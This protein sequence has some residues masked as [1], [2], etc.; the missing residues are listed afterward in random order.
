MAWV[1]DYRPTTLNKVLGNEYLVE[2]LH[3]MLVLDKLPQALMFVGERGTGKTSTARI[4]ASTLMC[5]NRNEDG[6]R[7][8]NCPTCQTLTSNLIIKGKPV[9][10]IPVYQYDIAK[11]N[12]REDISKIVERIQ[13]R[14]LHNQKTV[15]ILDEIQR[16]TPEAQSCFLK[17]IEEP[18]ANVY[19]FLC[20]T[21]PEKL[22][23]PLRSRFHQMRVRKP[24]ATTMTNHLRDICER[25]GVNY[26][27]AALQIV[28]EK[29][30]CIPREAI[31]MLEF[32]SLT[33]DVTKETVYKELSLVQDQHY[34]TFF[35]ACLKGNL[36]YIM[37]M[38]ESLKQEARIDLTTFVRGLGVYVT[39][40]LK[41]RAGVQDMNYTSA[42][43]K[44]MRQFIRRFSDKQIAQMLIL[45]EN[46]CSHEDVTDFLL[47]SLAVQVAD[48]VVH[49]PT[50]HV[51][52]EDEVGQTYMA[53]TEQI[54]EQ[55]TQ[56][57]FSSFA[58][59]TPDDLLDIF[60]TTP[61]VRT[62]E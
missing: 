62:P 36:V 41:V 6:G 56:R 52:T 8:S 10:G 57:S 39:D 32:I 34:Q 16:A 55:S 45:F 53:V 38:I 54:T 9:Q 61:E 11:F 28:A 49:I 46:A 12:K 26:S 3:N 24:N 60:G 19:I 35:T 58:S 30:Q 18:P 13:Q 2:K 20:T 31:N 17:V 51:P 40:L 37:Q 25:E 27:L 48:I 23:T 43:I 21:N 14:L 47:T 15:F 7:C 4:L 33:G 22:I 59:A 50:V 44:A 1:Q 42:E 5:E 29:Y